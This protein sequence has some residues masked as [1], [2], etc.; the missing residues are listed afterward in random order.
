[1]SDA[2]IAPFSQASLCIATTPEELY[3]EIVVDTPLAPY[4]AECVSL[5]D[6]TALN[7][8][9]IRNTLYKAYLEDF[10]QYCQKL[11]GATSEIMSELLEF[12]ADR[13]AINITLHSF[14][15]S[16]KKDERESLYAHFGEL[17]PEGIFKLSRA[18]EKATVASIVE[19]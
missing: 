18:D 12:E 14:G 19:P 1:M 17:F 3:R 4:F 9:I 15:T 11:G 8:E 2:N 5:D 7:I 10:Y 6:L 13:R 16:L